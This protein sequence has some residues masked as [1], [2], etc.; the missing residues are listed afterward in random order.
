M[1]ATKGA[2]PTVD[3]LRARG[4]LRG[5][6]AFFGPA[7]VAAIAYVDPGNF[8]TNFSAGA[9]FGYLLLWVIVGANLLAMLIQTLSA[10]LGLATGRNLPEMCRER[11]PRPVTRVMWVQAELVAIATDL[12]E[13]IGG[14]IALHL[15]FG[16][17]LLTGGVI[18]G[19]VAF[20]LLA[21]Q[22][23]GYRPF[24]LAI[25]GL[26][27]VILLGFLS[28]VLRIGIDTGDAVAGLVPRFE[29]TDSLLLATGILG[30][31][32]MPHVIYLHSAL[33]NTRIPATSVSDRRFLLRY[34]QLDVL[35]G[36][37]LAGLINASMLLISAALFFGSD[38]PATD[39]L[40]GVH[41]GLARVL[42]QPAAFAFALALL[43]SG[44]AS[45]G[46]GTYAGQVVMQ[47]FIRRR[48]PLLLRRLL[49]I[50]PALVVLGVGWDPTRAL[51]LSQVVLS[52]GIPF[53]LVPLVLLTRRRD[54]MAEL[55]NRRITTVVAG[56]AATV[57]IGLNAFLIYRT[58][59]GG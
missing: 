21:L 8:A 41:A 52:F 9:E 53:A 55:V 3:E 37:G 51:V 45:S 44:F 48:I 32:V 24:E 34:Q 39:T 42:D 2:A 26:F 25:A 10:K 56:L 59:T 4:G 23:K 19:I 22:G 7:I 47:G 54:V 36:M 28:T 57:I 35:V 12:A 11:F 13:V 17:P 20:A 29:G 31:T 43:A 5:R 58:V 30:A 16:I 38:V 1:T 49:T 6:L 46:V 14:A 50:T 18:T 40:E 27:A 33:T 15:L